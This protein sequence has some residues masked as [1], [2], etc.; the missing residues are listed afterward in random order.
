MYWQPN[1]CAAWLPGASLRCDGSCVCSLFS[2]QCALSARTLLVFADAREHEAVAEA[3]RHRVGGRVVR[4]VALHLRAHVGQHR[5]LRVAGRQRVVR[6]RR[7]E[8][9]DELP[10]WRLHRTAQNKTN[11]SELKRSTTSNRIS[12]GEE[13]RGRALIAIAFL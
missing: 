10:D 3:V 9:V 11:W 6:G 1:S 5:R 8:I 2:V 7:A 4:R 12:A 13:W